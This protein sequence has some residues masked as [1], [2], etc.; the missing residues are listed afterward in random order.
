MVKTARRT[1]WIGL[2]AGVALLVVGLVI[3]GGSAIAAGDWWL[4][5]EPWIGY[6]L[7]LSLIGLAV[8]GV[9]VLWLDIVE[10]LG[11]LRLLAVLPALAAALCW[12]VLLVFGIPT[13][14]GGP[15]H[16]PATI[17]YSVGPEFLVLIVVVTMLLALPLV[18]TLLARFRQLG[19]ARRRANR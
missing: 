9:C 7:N 12:S 8:T 5:R 13:G 11:W 1:G 4:A 6:G 3:T 16:D 15:A 2:G 18:P 10:P 17:V 14:F 19:S